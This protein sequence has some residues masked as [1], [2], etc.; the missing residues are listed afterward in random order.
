VVGISF[1]SDDLASAAVF[2]HH[3]QIAICKYLDKFAQRY[4]AMYVA[5]IMAPVWQW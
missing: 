4:T 5:R 2:V 3:L 1:S